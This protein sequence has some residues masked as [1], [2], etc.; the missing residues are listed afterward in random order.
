MHKLDDQEGAIA[1]ALDT[2]E[3]FWGQRPRSWESP[4]LTETDETLDL[5]RKHGVEYVA[6]L[7]DRR[8]AAGG[9][10]AARG[11]SPTIPY[12]VETTTSPSM[13]C[14]ATSPTSS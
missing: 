12:T 10:D 6:D 1:Q 7:G 13:R 5:L 14:K 3:G 11:S 4:G 9:G 8:S 2:I